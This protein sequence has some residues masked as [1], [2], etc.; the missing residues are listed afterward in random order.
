MLEKNMDVSEEL[1]IQILDY[2]STTYIGTDLEYP[3]YRDDL[4]EKLCGLL[5]I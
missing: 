1:K 2:I 3:K 4:C 5:T